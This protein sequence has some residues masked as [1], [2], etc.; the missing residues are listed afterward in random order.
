MTSDEQN[1]LKVHIEY[2]NTIPLFEFKE[3]LEGLN[4]QYQKHLPPKKDNE[5][6][7]ILLIKEIRPGS[8]DIHLVASIIPLI[9]DMNNITTFI[10]TIKSLLNWLSTLKGQK[11]KYTSDDVKDIVSM[12][13]PITN[14]DRSIHISSNG[15]NNETCIIDHVIAKKIQ[16]NAP[17]AYAQLLPVERPPAE[18]LLTKNN[19]VLRFK[20]V[21]N[22]EK[23]N[24]N[25][26]GIIDE[27]DSK[28]YPIMFA[29]GLKNPIIHG[30][31][32]PLKK[33]YLVDIKIQKIDNKIKSYTVLKISDSYIEENSLFLENE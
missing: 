17:V 1:L 2:K 20:Q 3:I 22:E 14:I 10:T 27:I 26:K 13:R 15:N 9:S 6:N 24:K 31:P 23:N 18:E 30:D 33:N 7:E 8:I 28:P 19:T 25:T 4:N 5:E 32:N 29:E 16:D 12:V 21:E 11:P